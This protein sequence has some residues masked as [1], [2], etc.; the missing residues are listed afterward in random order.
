MTAITDWELVAVNPTVWTFVKLEP[1]PDGSVD[2]HV[3]RHMPDP[4][5]FVDQIA[6]ERSLNDNKKWDDGQ[7]YGRI[8]DA[9]LYNTDYAKAKKGG[10]EAWLKRFWNSNE[11]AK[12][13]TKSGRV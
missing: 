12:L 6:D 5:S 3:W 7:V 10:D 9:F 8:P 13:R 2:L 4:Q 11:N 1:C